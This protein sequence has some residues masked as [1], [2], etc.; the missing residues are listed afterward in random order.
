MLSR[1][2]YTVLTASLLLSSCASMDKSI[3]VSN[4]HS[5]D[6]PAVADMADPSAARIIAA[7]KNIQTVQRKRI[8][9][10]TVTDVIALGASAPPLKP[11]KIIEVT[12]PTVQWARYQNDKKQSGEAMNLSIKYQGKA[13]NDQATS[14][15]YWITFH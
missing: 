2:L 6:L 10:M 8:I 14:A 15:W 11:G 12:V 9:I 13:Q 1:C 3:N 7:V 4:E 5:N